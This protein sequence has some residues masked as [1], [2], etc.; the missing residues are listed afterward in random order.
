MQKSSE[1]LLHGTRH[2]NRTNN[3]RHF[4]KRDVKDLQLCR[5]FTG[6]QDMLSSDVS[7]VL[8]E[9]GL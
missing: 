3:N 2:E 4:Q 5:M 6:V 1:M 9:V 7:A 8:A